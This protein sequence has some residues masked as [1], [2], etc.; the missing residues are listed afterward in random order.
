MRRILTLDDISQGLEALIRLDPR[1]SAVIERAGAVPL[2][3]SE[4]GFASLVAIVV[5]QQVS[6]ASAPVEIL[7]GDVEEDVNPYSGR[8]IHKRAN[9]AKPEMM[10]DETTFVST[11]S[12]RVPTAYFVPADQKVAL[13][14][15]R[16]HGVRLERL[17][18]PVNVPLQEFQVAT[19]TATE[20]P[21]EN[22]QERTVT[23]TWVP[24]ERAVP[25]GAYRVSMNQ[26]LA[27]LAFYL[28]EPRSNDGLAT[29]NVLDEALKSGRSPIVR[30][31]N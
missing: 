3:L 26:P 6:R 23:G 31:R 13:E 7:M 21:F 24:V 20:K 27:R 9:V 30:T 2:R 15:L 22:H 8:V 19:S 17:D 18:A 28:L 25:A 11:D 10:A 29:W 4:P 16:A 5:S 12:E 14:R 1:L